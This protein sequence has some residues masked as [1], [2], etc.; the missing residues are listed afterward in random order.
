MLDAMTRTPNEIALAA[1]RRSPSDPT[2][3]QHVYSALAARAFELRVWIAHYPKI[4][5][6][7]R[8]YIAVVDLM[9]AMRG[10]STW[11]VRGAVIGAMLIDGFVTESDSG[12][13][14]GPVGWTLAT[15]VLFDEPVHD[16]LGALGTFSLPPAVMKAVEQ[17]WSSNPQIFSWR[18]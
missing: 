4:A 3:A 6:Y 12:W 10:G 1:I 13:F 8:D 9:E 16:V 7:P 11:T 15:A 14:V 5:E 18:S 2:S 17:R